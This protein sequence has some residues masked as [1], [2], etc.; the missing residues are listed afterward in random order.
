MFAS[1]ER[2]LEGELYCIAKRCPD[3]SRYETALLLVLLFIDE[4]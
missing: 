2:L 1:F 3:D 4:V